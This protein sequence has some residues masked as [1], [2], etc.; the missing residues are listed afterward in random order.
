MYRPMFAA[1]WAASMQIYDPSDPEGKVANVIGGKVAWNIR[2][3]D[4][5]SRWKNTCAVRMSYIL[6]HSGVTIPAIAGRTVTGA[7]N[8]RYFYRV[9]DLI[10]FLKQRWGVPETMA[11]PPSGGGKLAGKR[12]VILFETSG[13]RDAQGHA[14]LYNGITCYD[15]CY[16]NEP[17][18]AYR[19]DRAHFWSLT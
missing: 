7:D 2:D 19:T 18:S 15:S 1:A 9:I 4:I 3:A 14:T 16:F 12:G 11:Y 6:N 8:R 5:E 17:G 13:W 10:P